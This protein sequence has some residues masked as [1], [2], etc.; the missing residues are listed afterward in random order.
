MPPSIKYTRGSNNDGIELRRCMNGRRGG[1]TSHW[2]MAPLT[3]RLRVKSI[4]GLAGLNFLRS[5]LLKAIPKPCVHYLDVSCRDCGNFQALKKHKMYITKMKMNSCFW[6]HYNA[7]LSNAS[8]YLHSL[9]IF[10]L[11]TQFSSTSMGVSS[12]LQPSP[13][14]GMLL[15][16]HHPKIGLLLPRRGRRHKF[17]TVTN[18]NVSILNRVSL[19]C[20]AHS[21]QYVPQHDFQEE[22]EWEEMV[23]SFSFPGDYDENV[24]TVKDNVWGN[25]IRRAGSPVIQSRKEKGRI[26]GS[27]PKQRLEMP[28]QRFKSDPTIVADPPNVNDANGLSSLQSGHNSENNRTA[29]SSSEVT[30]MSSTRNADQQLTDHMQLLNEK[31]VSNNRS[32]DNDTAIKNKSARNDG[33]GCIIDSGVNESRLGAIPSDRRESKG[34]TELTMN[35]ADGSSLNNA[36]PSRQLQPSSGYRRKVDGPTTNFADKGF[37]KKNNNSNK[38]AFGTTD[39]LPTQATTVSG[40]TNIENQTQ[41]RRRRIPPEQISQI[42]STINILDVIESYNLPQFVRTNSHTAKA[43][44]PFHDDHN[45]SMSV[46]GQRGLYKCFACGAGGDVFNFV[47]EYDV[48]VAKKTNRGVEK[49]SYLRAVAYVAHEF[50][51]ASLVADWG[52][53]L[54]G[55]GGK[56]KGMSKE[57]REKLTER[58]RKKDR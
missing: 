10:I 46:D 27:V 40:I 38:A 53:G 2:M 22:E 32:S 5:L 35:R 55:D 11:M 20:R 28:L 49:M 1:G 6:R 23:A 56:Y 54:E 57:V 15:P 50:G 12:F 21:P 43:C 24:D 47:R 26:K 8:F 58:E 51:D 17:M 14:S 16:S 44:C 34:T 3:L 45:P 41:T 36:T 19:T 25:S 39:N 4:A 52:I 18:E 13:S 7:V 29:H 33:N 9:I 37:L 31:F 30:L 42:K 48:I